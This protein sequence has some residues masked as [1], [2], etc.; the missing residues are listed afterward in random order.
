MVDGKG[1]CDACSCI[2]RDR[3]REGLAEKGEDKW[4]M[5]NVRKKGIK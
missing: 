2:L 1:V 4:R 3:Q 5:K